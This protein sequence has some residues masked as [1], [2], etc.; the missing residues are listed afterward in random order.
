M[1]QRRQ[2]TGRPHRTLPRYHRKNVG[3]QEP[4]H[5]VGDR[6]AHAGG[7]ARHDIGT[8]QQQRPHGLSWQRL[9]G[10]NRM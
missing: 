10:T 6:R 7:A 2:V 9:A 4:E 3:T 8:Q 1:C 5:L